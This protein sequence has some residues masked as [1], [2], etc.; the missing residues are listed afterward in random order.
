VFVDKANITVRGGAG[1]NGAVSFYRG[2]YVPNGGPDG[3]DGG[4]GGSVYFIA[5]NNITTLMDFKLKKAYNAQDGQ[6]GGKKNCYGKKGADLKIRVPVGTVIREAE[7]GL[8]MADMHTAGMEIALIKGGRGGRGNS[9]FAT[10]VRQAP[11]YSEKGRPAK[12][13]KV[14]L[15]LK[16]I[17][18]VGIIGLP[19]VGKS[20]L[21]SMVTNANPKIANYHFTTLFP[22]L[23]VVRSKGGADF[24]LADIPGLIAGASE[25]AGLGFDFL[26]HIERTKVLCHIVDAAAVEG[27]DPLADIDIV[28]AE[29]AAYSPVLMSKPKVIAA[30]KMDIPEAKENFPRIKEAWEGEGCVV[31]PI[32]A[33][34][35]EGLTELIR[36][37]ERLVRLAPEEVVFEGEYTEAPD[38]ARA[39]A[40][41]VHK[42]YEGCF[43]VEGAGVERMLGY[44]NLDDENGMA[45]FQKYI[46]ERGIAAE[47]ERQGA[48][49][50]DTVKIYNLEFEYFK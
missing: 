33:A 19:N 30:N 35:G 42:P 1:G 48:V 38:G 36:V 12:E 13:Y 46:R 8:V 23:G 24:T 31:M 49:D 37:L 25:G 17:A 18:D 7:S 16:L 45:F 28:N 9:K 3:G 6:P 22:N 27:G 4:D 44:T 10:A 20:T 47:L 50:G 32:S 21:L 39:A 15:D 2:K 43:V 14:T 41:T 11:K 26:G 5:D 34:T 29:L 40:F